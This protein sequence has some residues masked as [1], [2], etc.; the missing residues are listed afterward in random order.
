[1]L[2]FS[3]GKVKI[4]YWALVALLFSALA[5][6]NLQA[7]VNTAVLSGTV[8]DTT[9]A[10]IA[11]AQ[12]QATDVGTGISYAGTTD[13][14]GRYTLPE[15]PIGTYNVAAQKTGFQKLVQTGIVLTIGAHP[16]LDFTLKVGHTSE[17]VEVHGQASTVETTTAAVGQ[18][19]SPVQMSDLPLNGRDFTDLLT[20][21]PGV[22]RVASGAT[23]GGASA[24]GYG[25]E[26]NYS[27]S[28]S[29]PVG[30]A[31]ELDDLDVRDAQDHGTGAGSIGTSLGMEAIQEFQIMT[32]TYSAEFGGTGA[33][34]NMATKSGTNSLHGS[35]YGFFRNSALDATNWGD[36]PG[37]KPSFTRNQ[38]G[39]SLGGPVKK[40]KAF[41]FVNYEGLRNNTGATM[42]GAVPTSL[43]DLYAAAG[44]TG[45][46]TS[47]TNPAYAGNGPLPLLTQS[48]FAEY[49]T[50]QTAAQCPNVTNTTYLGGTGP[51]CWIGNSIQNE[52]YGLAR[53]D[54]NF[55][56][57]DS[58][59][60][61][62]T[63]EHAYQFI[64][65]I[66]SLI[67]GWP[68]VDNEQNQYIS[69]EERHVFSPTILNELHVGFVR[70]NFQSVG[71]GLNG[72]DDLHQVAGKQDMDWAPGQG[73]TPIGPPPSS[74]GANAT[75]RFSVGDDVV[76]TKGAHSLHV[77]ILFTRVQTNGLAESYSAGWWLFAGL[78]GIPLGPGFA[79]GGSMQGSPLVGFAGVDPSYTYTTPG[80]KSYPWTPMR[81]WRQNWLD[82]YIQDDWKIS[83]RLTLNLGV[84][85]EFAGNPTTV[86]QP[87]FVLP[88]GFP[89]TATETSFVTAQHPFTSNPN[90][91]NIDP[92]V[93]L[94][95]DPFGDHKTAVLAGF[96]MFHEPVQART[97]ASSFN[98]QNPLFD[99]T[100]PSLY[101]LY[102]NLPTALF[103]TAQLAT[104][105]ITW[106]G[107]ILNNV[108]TAPYV[109]QFNLTVQRQILPGTVF[110]IGYVGSEGVH[111][112][113]QIDANLPQPLSNDPNEAADILSPT[114]TLPGGGQPTGT[115]APGT[116]NNPFIGTHVNGN[117]AAVDA[118]EPIAHSNYNSLQTSVTRQF[119]RDLAGNAGYTW[120]KCLDNGSATTSAE[121]GE[122]A[123]YNAYNPKLDRGPCSYN[124]NQVFTANAIYSLPFHA[125]RAVSG[126]QI[127]PIISRFSGLPIN[128]QN[129]LF[130]YQSNIGGSVEGER[131]SR[132]S[133]CNPLVKKLHSEWWNPECFVEMPFGTIG[134]AGRDS[135]ENPNYFN[136]DFSVMKNTK[137]TE[138]MSVQLRAEFFDILNHPNFSVGQQA[139]LMSTTSTIN[140]TSAGSGAFY[141]Q[142]GTPAAY[143][144]P[145]PATGFAG[146]DIC[147][148]PVDGVQNPSA[149]VV[150]P[151]YVSTTAAG[152][153]M[154]YREIQFAVK[155]TF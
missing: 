68:E 78:N 70:L 16:V 96:G 46:G 104:Q 69:I 137:L 84:R 32:N 121:Q 87:V 106:F 135:V 139:Y 108:D 49:P 141:S 98:P 59:F 152:S 21:A 133:G 26:T 10:V 79:A 101:G 111:E 41:Y 51:Y 48:L 73:L 52:S 67:P 11:G 100:F 128:I 88:N 1:M 76:L 114:Y 28:G 66:E 123:V 8:L 6:S 20:L 57:K 90:M 91:K 116:P 131:P 38:F 77:G 99:V 153:T 18:L 150:G 72:H 7:Q 36:I 43:P 94:A 31:Y 53:V 112:F 115:G 142:I 54:Y 148:P 130:V 118:D 19:V 134:N 15:M 64:P 55:G 109:M 107:A 37:Q 147:N 136:M 4:V 85:Y 97:F 122:W 58:A 110:K 62:Y 105:G 34:I 71:G 29:R 151:C 129:M 3:L 143:E 45:S 27:V 120:S 65:T 63:I 89:S 61:R 60:A 39:G 103:P 30:A 124:S 25:L 5:V 75:N 47:W 113:S 95:W 102:P 23:G 14:A 138:R 145:N 40:D 12:I 44:Y 80:G 81:Y 24:T 22:G 93:G 154:S 33:A 149:A 17:V 127:S 13:G 74:P 50:A 83:K 132:V 144:P 117:F 86:G 155:L 9:G 146:G 35:A 42:R 125:N 2:K 82:P 140:S 92:R 56:A 119:S 126:W